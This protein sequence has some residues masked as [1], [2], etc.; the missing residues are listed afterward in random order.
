MA[1]RSH[2]G[3][4]LEPD[5]RD[6]LARWPARG[7]FRSS[8]GRRRR[9]GAA[10]SDR[11]RGSG[12]CPGVAGRMP[13]PCSRDSRGSARARAERVGGGAKAVDR[14]RG[15]RDVEAGVARLSRRRRSPVARHEVDVVGPSRRGAVRWRRAASI[16]PL[17]GEPES[18]RQSAML[19]SMRR[20]R[21]RSSRASTRCR[22]AGRLPRAVSVCDDSDRRVVGDGPH[23]RVTRSRRAQGAQRAERCRWRRPAG[24][25][26][27]HMAREC[28][29]ELSRRSLSS[30][31]VRRIASAECVGDSLGDLDQSLDESTAPASNCA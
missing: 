20:R 26:R 27:A 18:A 13:G 3:S 21:A 30:R 8:S 24:G 17:S 4:T 19:A 29:L 28:R 25:A 16:W 14:V 7:G 6:R 2:S 31:R 23:A 12:A 1:S 22:R 11:R 9:R 5:R 10:R 15:R